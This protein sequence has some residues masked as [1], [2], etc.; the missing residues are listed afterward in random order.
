MPSAYRLGHYP[1]GDTLDWLHHPRYS[2]ARDRALEYLA[3]ENY[4]FRR[5]QPVLFICGG[6]ESTRRERLAGYIRRHHNHVM[7]FYAEPVWAT[8]AAQD[9]SDNALEM[10]EKLAHLA[11]MVMVIV[12]SPGTFAELGAFAISKPLRQKMIPILD[13]EHRNSNSFV[14][15]GPVRWIDA[16]SIFA[17]SIWTSL[18]SILESAAD[19]DER[20]R[21][22]PQQ[23][24]QSL[25]DLA[26]SPKHL[27]FF[28]CDLVAVFGPC[29][30][31]HLEFYLSRLLPK[32]LVNPRLELGLGH[33]LG[34]VESFEHE[35]TELYFRPLQD[36][37]LPAF[38][39]KRKYI[40]I[41]T[42]RAEMLA[43][44]QS[45]DASRAALA[46][47]GTHT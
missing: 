27:V 43:A 18:D 32:T 7:V 41:P 8:I 14:R 30:T 40:D 20:I 3:S 34:L 25:A 24:A 44:M 46:R 29:S 2:R 4:R 13:S 19:I 33:A 21:K 17:P 5:L 47:M 1:V 42:L 11:D 37:R 6:F 15:T 45:C 35:G 28:I 9:G 23:R 12:E 26:S 39:K 22:I 16:D 36:G 10:E 38:Q 31:S